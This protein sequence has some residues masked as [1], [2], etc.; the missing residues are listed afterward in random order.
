MCNNI[1]C[2][3]FSNKTDKIQQRSCIKWD[4]NEGKFKKL[5]VLLNKTR[6][7]SLCWGLKSGDVILFGG[8]DETTGDTERVSRSGETS[9]IAFPLD[10]GHHHIE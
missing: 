9:E 6:D 4:E 3:G 1:I 7:N 2:G 10:Q 5:P 8:H